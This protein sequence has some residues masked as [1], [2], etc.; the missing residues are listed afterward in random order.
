MTVM[1]DCVPNP[2]MIVVPDL[3]IFGS[4]DPVAVDK[5]C[6]DAETNAAQNDANVEGEIRKD[7]A[8]TS[9]RITE[10]SKEH[11]MDV[12]LER[13]KAAMRPSESKSDD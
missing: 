9:L 2:G 11:E 6:V 10:M 3:G 1:C 12:E 5:A 7:V 13:T 4:I 8:E